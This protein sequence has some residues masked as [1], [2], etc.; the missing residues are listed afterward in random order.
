MPGRLWSISFYPARLLRWKMMTPS[1][2]KV[3][4][5][6]SSYAF[7]SIAA[8]LA[9]LPISYSNQVHST[10]RAQCR[11]MRAFD[12]GKPQQRGR[13]ADRD[14]CTPARAVAARGPNKFLRSWSGSLKDLGRGLGQ[15]V[16]PELEL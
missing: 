10:P 15:R 14:G 13:Q 7:P 12:G 16:L 2:L 6:V 9:S 8:S 3:F 5:T 11:P 1:R 4:V